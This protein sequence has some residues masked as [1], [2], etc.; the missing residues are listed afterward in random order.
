ML[1]RLLQVMLEYI[2]TV[3]IVKITSYTIEESM[4]I[5]KHF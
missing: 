2:V 4:V 3:L 1:V 5:V